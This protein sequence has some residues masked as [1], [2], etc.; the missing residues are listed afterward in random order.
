VQRGVTLG[1]ENQRKLAN[2][3]FVFE[4]YENVPQVGFCWDIGHETCFAGGREYMPL[5]GNRLVYTH[6]H[7]NLCQKDGDLHM[8]P[9]DGAIDFGRRVELLRRFNY[10]GSLTLELHPGKCG[11]YNSL[12]HQEYFARAYAAAARLRAM[13]DGDQPEGE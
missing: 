2:L 4:L 3:A 10:Q 11:K 1:F 8:I 6:I 9:F 13:L 5:F 12:S 7:D